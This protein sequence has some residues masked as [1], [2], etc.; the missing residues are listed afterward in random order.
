MDIK[1]TLLKAGLVLAT[2]AAAFTVATSTQSTKAASY[3]GKLVNKGELTIGLEGTYQPYSY[4]KDGKL[5]GFE[6]ELGQQ[7]AKKMGLKAKFVPTKWDS[8]IAGVGANKF[9]VALNNISETPERQKSYLFSEPYIYSRSALISLKK[10]KLDSAKS[11]K[12]QKLA[13]GTGTNNAQIA[14]KLGAKIVNSDQFTTSIDMIRQ[15]RVKGTINAAEAYYAY[16]KTQ[17]HDDLNMK[18]LPEKDVPASKVSALMAKKNTKLQKEFNKAL[19]E[20][21]DDG[22]LTKLSKKYFGEDITK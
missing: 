6:V 11:V 19:K 14:K 13:E 4:R 9:D 2:A 16:A 21:K 20:L 10:D 12:G 5:T 17:K 22:T 3:D 18:V 1:K 7:V 15:G 8:L